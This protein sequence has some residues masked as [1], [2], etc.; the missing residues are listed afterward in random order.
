MMASSTTRYPSED[1]SHFPV[2]TM[3]NS[4]GGHIFSWLNPCRVACKLPNVSL[5]SKD[6]H[7]SFFEI[8]NIAEPFLKVISTN[9]ILTGAQKL[10]DEKT[11][12]GKEI[13]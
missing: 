2:C 4:A 11:G 5:I 8:H 9:F 3:L 12:S 10:K 6:C 1:L 7:D 13:T